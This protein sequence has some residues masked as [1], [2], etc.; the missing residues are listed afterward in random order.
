MERKFEAPGVKYESANDG[1]NRFDD[2]ENYRPNEQDDEFEPSG[3]LAED[4]Y[5]EGFDSLDSNDEQQEDQPGH[6][7]SLQEKIE[8]GWSN[9]Y[10]KQREAREAAA[11]AERAAAEEQEAAANL[12]RIFAEEMHNGQERRIGGRVFKIIQV[13]AEDPDKIRAA[14]ATEEAAGVPIP[15]ATLKA[16]SENVD[17]V[18]T[19]PNA[20]R[21]TDRQ[22]DEEY[23]HIEKKSNESATI[24]NTAGTNEGAG[25]DR[26]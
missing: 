26:A 16:Q 1:W 17:E 13:Q 14:A 4:L 2:G 20:T 10:R 22:L 24:D 25:Q 12:G 18:L 9:Y 6:E 7:E 11:A 5:G 3:K 23:D 19:N 15:G 8:Q 21:A